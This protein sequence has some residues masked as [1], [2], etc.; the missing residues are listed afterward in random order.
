MTKPSAST[1]LEIQIALR[2][3]AIGIYS[4]AYKGVKL[5][6][7]EP[8][9]ASVVHDLWHAFKL[10]GRHQRA[11]ERTTALFREAAGVSP[12]NTL[13]AA[14]SQRGG[15]GNGSDRLVRVHYNEAQETLD[16][17][18]EF[19]L[20]WHERRL[21][22]LLRLDYHNK[23]RLMH[24]D[25]IGLKLSGYKDKAQARAAAAASIHRLLDSLAEFYGL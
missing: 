10:S 15:N 9:R 6:G 11:W 5:S 8:E 14:L 16:R 12:G 21:L 4:E 3:V 19:H 7:F 23:G 13:S 25:E 24:L 20:R 18:Y 2:R 1:E 17:I 22:E